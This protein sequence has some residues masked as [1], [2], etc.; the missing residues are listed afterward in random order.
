M[1]YYVYAI[2]KDDTDNRLYNVFESFKE[3]EKMEKE[4]KAGNYPGDNYFV[5]MFWAENDRD[6]EEKADALRPFPKL[7][8]NKK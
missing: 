5:R 1:R 3:A 8:K 6:A 2:H 4:M 7:P